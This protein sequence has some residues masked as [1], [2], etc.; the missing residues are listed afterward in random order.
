MKAWKTSQILTRPGVKA[1]FATGACHGSE[2][3]DSKNRPFKYQ[4]GSIMKQGFTE[5]WI[6]VT[7]KR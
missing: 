7:E 4:R 2:N 3:S 1:S 5:Y 6:N